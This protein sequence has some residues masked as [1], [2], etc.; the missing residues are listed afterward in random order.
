LHWVIAPLSTN[1]DRV[2][3]GSAEYVLVG[4]TDPTDDL[5]NRGVLGSASLLAD[6]TNSIVESD[7]QLG[8]AGEVWTASGSGAITSNLFNGLYSTV[9]VNGSSGA[10]GSF[11]GVFSDSASGVPSAAGLSYQLTNSSRTVSGAA[12]FNTTSAGSAVN[13]SQ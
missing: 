8:I 13:T 11:G 7:L 4:N 6:F 1:P 10:S 2:I 12:V 5:G 3:T 9:T